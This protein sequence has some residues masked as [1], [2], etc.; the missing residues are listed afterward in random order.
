MSSEEEQKR[1]EL[2]KQKLLAR[3]GKNEDALHEAILTGNVKTLETAP[4]TP[5]VQPEPVDRATHDDDEHINLLQTGQQQP[6]AGTTADIYED[7]RKTL[8]NERQYK[9]Y[10]NVKSLLSIVAGIISAVMVS[11]GHVPGNVFLTLILADVVMILYF[12]R[13]L[14]QKQPASSAEPQRRKI[15]DRPAEKIEQLLRRLVL[16]FELVDDISS[17]IVPF[18]CTLCLLKLL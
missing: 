8:K 2:R 7:Y 3:A 12:G 15:E 10:M 9:L 17:F 1:R 16:L 5:A 13:S 18:I 6:A 4:Q 14:K 11:V